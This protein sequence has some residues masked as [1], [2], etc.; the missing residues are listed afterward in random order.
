VSGTEN[1]SPAWFVSIEV[2]ES[3]LSPGR[4]I[5]D[6]LLTLS[7]ALGGYTHP[8]FN[9]Q[10]WAARSPIGSTPLPGGVLVGLMGGLAEQSGLFDGAELVLSGFETVRFLKP[11]IVGDT[12]RVRVTV[13]SKE[14]ARSGRGGKVEVKFEGRNQR[15]EEV[16]T[17]G[18]RFFCGG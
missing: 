13:V 17:L 10:S 6:S 15:D 5:T 3:R 2:G 11:V 8:L 18:A 4:T 14:P 1:S 16:A 9:D 12:L 7:I